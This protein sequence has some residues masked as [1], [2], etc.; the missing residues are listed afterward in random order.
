MTSYQPLSAQSAR[1][2]ITIQTMQRVTRVYADCR[3]FGR[4]LFPGFIP[5]QSGGL[6]PQAAHRRLVRFFLCCFFPA[7]PRSL[8]EQNSEVATVPLGNPG[9][10]PEPEWLPQRR[11]VDTEAAI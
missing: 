2:I 10:F 7:P 9:F 5:A 11:A 3:I 1:D 6:P 8:P 4:L